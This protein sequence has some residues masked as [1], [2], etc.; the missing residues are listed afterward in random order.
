MGVGE[1]LTAA[2]A[3]LVVCAMVDVDFVLLGLIVGGTGI[4]LITGACGYRAYM[5]GDS[6][7]T[8][9]GVAGAYAGLALAAGALGI[10]AHIA[11]AV[12]LLAAGLI[13]ALAVGPFQR[14]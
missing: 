6:S 3:V 4:A 7:G 8:T 10:A 1:V 13:T 12:A 5:A 14:R 11:L 9:A 2:G